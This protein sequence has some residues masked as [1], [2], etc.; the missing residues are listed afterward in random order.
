MTFAKEIAGYAAA[1][2]VAVLGCP[3]QTA[4]AWLDGTRMP[5]EWQRDHWLRIL[6]KEVP[7]LRRKRK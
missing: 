4:Y 6:R 5:P 1:E 7:K 3:R 2:I